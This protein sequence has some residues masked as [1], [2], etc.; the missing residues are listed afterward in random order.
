MFPTVAYIQNDVV[1]DRIRPKQHCEHRPAE[2]LSRRD[3]LPPV[4]RIWRYEQMPRGIKTVIDR[5]RKPISPPASMQIIRSC[6]P[7][8]RQGMLCV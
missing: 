8:D 6:K 4:T 3:V 7:I 2:T 5:N 1:E